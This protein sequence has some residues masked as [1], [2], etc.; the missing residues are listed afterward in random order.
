MLMLANNNHSVITKMAKTSLKRNQKKNMV[1]ILAVVLASFMLFSCLTVGVTYVKMEQL[2]NIRMSGAEMDAIMY[3]MTHEQEEKI[4]KDEKIEKIGVVGVAGYADKTEYDTTLHTGLVWCDDVYWN[5]MMA[6]A[7]KWTK[8]HYPQK[9]NEV[10]VTRAALEDCGFS[11]LGIGDSFT[12]TYGD[13]NGLELKEKTFVISGIWEGYGTKKVFYVSKDF[14]EQSGYELSDVRSGRVYFQFKNFFMSPKQQEEFRESMNLGIQQNLYFEAETSNALRLMLGLAGLIFITCLCAYLLIYNI[15]YLSVSGNI[16]YYGLLQTVGM[17][18][19][20]VKELMKKQVRLVGILGIGGGILL[21]MATSFVFIP[22]AVKAFGIR[23]KVQV[24][25]RPVIFLLT[26]LIAAVTLI[27]G[28]R[29]PVK[30]A[31]A[32]S[33]VEAL[34]YRSVKE[35]RKFRRTRKGNILRNMAME[36]LTK[37]KKKTGVVV[38][39]LAASLSVFLLLITLLESQGPRTI[40]SNYMNADIEITNDTMEKEET[41]K[42]EQLLSDSFLQD[43]QKIEGV[44]ELHT[45]TSTKILV[46]WEPEFADTW[47]RAEYE[48]WMSESYEEGVERYQAHPEEYFSY[49]KGIDEAEFD[50]LNN[51]LESKV[52]KEAFME[53]KVAILYQNGVQLDEKAVKG[54]EVTYLLQDNPQ[55]T[56]T[57]TVAGMTGD[58]RYAGIGLGPNLIVSEKLVEKLIEDPYVQ[59]VTVSY[60]EEYD[61]GTEN[62]I[63]ESIKS[64]PHAKDFSYESKLEEMKAVTKAQGNMKGVGLGITLILALIGLMNYF[65]TVSGNIQNRQVELSVME[66]V[67][68]TEKQIYRMLMWEGIFYAGGSVLLM[69]TLGLGITYVCYQAMNY[70]GIAFAVPVLP[71][72]GSI[73][74]I[75]AVCIG[76]PI[77]MYRMLAGKKSIVERIRGFE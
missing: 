6:P 4:Q 16:R 45:M 31:T 47:M 46:P 68:M 62:Q 69:G 8:G 39:S 28:S 15:L 50:Y 63:L 22:I 36:Q 24:S 30:M 35:K 77:V 17:T 29:K 37:D 40:V 3:G 2:Q 5:E 1:L 60:K 73:L 58:N 21:G 64:Q 56:H 66:S 52:D 23:E 32:I 33:P 75:T 27:L 7:R 51:T 13:N 25:F 48:M 9:D 70:R 55:N 10:M 59:N 71:V 74:M 12:L 57:L 34:G 54:A 61:E 49:L 72:L 19:T 42:W 20:Q 67:G 11:N 43:L 26:L 14:Y 76:I 38:L 41:E 53:G 44:K 18:G 65:N